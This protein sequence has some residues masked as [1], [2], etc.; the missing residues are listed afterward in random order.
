MDNKIVQEIQR[1]LG[2]IEGG[3]SEMLRRFDDLDRKVIAHDVRLDKIEQ[4]NA[5]QKARLGIFGGGVAIIVSI[6]WDFIKSKFK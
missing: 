6:A 4:F 5:A 1:S 2:R 3:Q